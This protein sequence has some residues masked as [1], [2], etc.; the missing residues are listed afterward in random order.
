MPALADRC[1]HGLAPL[2]RPFAAVG[3]MA[4]S[5]YLL[6]SYLK[7][8]ACGSFIPFEVLTIAVSFSSREYLAPIRVVS[9]K[10][11]VGGGL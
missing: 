11:L 10:D 1:N 2:L 8:H 9:S 6:T 5:N 3:Q 4:L 7:Q